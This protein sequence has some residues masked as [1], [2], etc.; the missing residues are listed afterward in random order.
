MYT[1]ITLREKTNIKEKAAEWK[2]MDGNSYAWLRTVIR[3]K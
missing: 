1:Y 2:D 3:Q